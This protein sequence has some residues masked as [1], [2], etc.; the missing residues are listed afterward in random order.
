MCMKTFGLI[1]AFLGIIC[2]KLV[3]STNK[4]ASVP[5]SNKIHQ[6]KLNDINGHEFDF[7]NLK[8]HI[9]LLVNVASHCGFTNQYHGLQALF[10]DYKD[11]G[12]MVVGIPSNDFGNQEPGNAEEIKSFCVNIYNTSFPILE[13]SIVKGKNS[14]PLYQFLSDKNIH[15]KTGG[16]ITWNFNKFLIDGEGYVVKRYSSFTQPQSKKIIKDI[17]QLIQKQKEKNNEKN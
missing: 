2:I 15:P 12:L 10:N 1:I 16:P 13:K 4:N 5:T 9:I 11:Q 8:D 6:F 7:K 14:I 17:K 3:A